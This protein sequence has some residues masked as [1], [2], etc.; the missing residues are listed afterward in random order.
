MYA[1]KFAHLVEER[2]DA[3]IYQFYIDMRAYG[4]GY[5]EFYSR[6]MNEGAT[7]IRGK[8]AEIVPALAQGGQQRNGHLVIRCED[9]LM[10]KYREIPVD[11]VV[12]C[13][14]LEP[15]AD[16]ADVAN[17]F[18]LS[19]SPD[20]FF[21]ERHPKLDPVGTMNDGVYIAGTCQGPKDIPDT[22]AQAQAAAARILA[23]IGKGEVLIDPIRADISAD[24]CSGCRM[25]NA[26]CPY[27]AITFDEEKKVSEVNQTLCK[28]CG[29][30]VAACPAGAI[31]GSGFTDEQILAEL[32]A[33]LI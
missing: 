32:E 12:L 22:V 11:M 19:R 30:C 24:N 1:L 16:A 2:T 15:Q 10:G 26:L 31:S 20:G 21:L 9:T 25:C 27:Q 3:E 6:V 17:I 8:V 33:L 13:S 7:V 14:A 18:S 4:K 29:T 23:L 5:E 28:G